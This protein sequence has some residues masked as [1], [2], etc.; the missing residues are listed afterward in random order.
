MNSIF[1]AD[2]I[3]LLEYVFPVE[4]LPEWIRIMLQNERDFSVLAELC[5]L[6]SGRVSRNS[7][8][9]DEF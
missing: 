3:S 8:G 9:F 1:K 4:R 2:H 6:F 5:P 7:L